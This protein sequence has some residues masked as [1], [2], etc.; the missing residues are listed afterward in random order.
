MLSNLDRIFVLAVGLIVGI[1]ILSQPAYAN[2]VVGPL[3]CLWI[4]LGIISLFIIIFIEVMIFINVT[5]LDTGKAF[6]ASIVINII[7]TV[8]GLIIFYDGAGHDPTLIL[9]VACVIGLILLAVN[10]IMFR[11]YLLMIIGGIPLIIGAVGCFA[12]YFYGIFDTWESGKD[13]YSILIFAICFG[14]ALALEI[15]PAR[16]F[17]E[18]DEV[19]HGVLWGN[20]GSYIAVGILMFVF[21]VTRL[22]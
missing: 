12:Q 2:P 1:F 17:M 3:T 21:F 6:A 7:S 13:I 15:W 4:P 9:A 14:L 5:S 10:S 16:I 20:T 19:E 8:I 11:K 18:N 22:H